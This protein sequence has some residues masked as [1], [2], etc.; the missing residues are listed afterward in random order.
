MAKRERKNRTITQNI[1]ADSFEEL[2]SVKS[3]IYPWDD[4][5]DK[6]TETENFFIDCDDLD[7]ARGLK[8]S[9]NSSGLNYYLKRKINFVPVIVV[10]K[11]KNGKVGL[12]C[13]VIPAE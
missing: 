1:A 5:A 9:V 3:S 8:H 10:A 12:V 13:S 2:V 4:L 6:E 7:E 11:M